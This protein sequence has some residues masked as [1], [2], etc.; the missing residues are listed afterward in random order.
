MS[1]TISPSAKKPYSVA[2]I[3]EVWGV[4]RS[5]YYDWKQ[6][7]TTEPR[8]APQKP[9]PKTGLDDAEL[10]VRIRGILTEAEAL[11]LRGEGH[12]KVWARLRRKGTNTTKRRVLRLMRENELLAPTRV[13]RRRGPRTH[14][15]DL[16]TDRPDAMWGTDGTQVALLN[17]QLVW[18]FLAVDHCTGECIGVHASATGTR[19]EAIEPIRQGINEFIGPVDRGVADGLVIRHDHGSQYMSHF[20]QDELKFLG[21]TSSPSFVASPQGNGIAERFVRTLKEQLLW[22]DTFDTVEALL[23]ALQAFRAQYN[24][25]WLV[26][27]HGHRS[28]AEVRAGFKPSTAAQEAA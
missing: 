27:R 7:Q 12:R 3:C 10:L 21:A 17:G 9:G 20:F 26:Q 2:H 16:H 6:R 22:V 24:A 5:T 14:D 13:G 28:P 11:G 8:P 25:S 1:A 15:G 4:P 23:A 18:V 19:F